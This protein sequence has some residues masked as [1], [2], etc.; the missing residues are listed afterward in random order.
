MPNSIG[1]LASGLN[2]ADIINAILTG[3]QATRT[4][5]VSRQSTYQTQLNA[6]QDLNNRLGSLRSAAEALSTPAKAAAATATSSDTDLVSVTAGTGAVESTFSFKV[7]Q[8]AASHQVMANGFTDT[9]DLVGAGKAQVSAGLAGIGMALDNYTGL[10]AGKYEVQIKS[11]SGGSATVVFNGKEQSVSSSG[12]VTL[13]DAAGNS[14]DFTIGTLATGTATIGV[15]DATA[16]TSL[17]GLAGAIN[18]LGVGV[19]AAAVNK[20]DGT[21]TP[22]SFVLSARDPGTEHAVTMDFSNLSGVSGKTFSTLRAA[23]DARIVL[24]DGTTTITRSSNRL[25]DVIPGV[26]ID[27]KAADPSKEVTVTVD[28]DDEKVVQQAKTLVESLNSVLSAVKRSTS[29]DSATK[30]A[31]TLTGDSRMRR[32]QDALLEAMRYSDSGQDKEVLAQI[33]I[34]L[35]SNGLFSLDETKFR[36]ALSNDHTG[37]IRLLAGDGDTRTGAFGGLTTTVKALTASG[38]TVHG[39]LDATRTNI[40]SLDDRIA[41]EDQRLAL[42]ENRVRRQYTNLE[43]TMAQLSSQAA[44]LSNALG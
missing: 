31:A 4:R 37:T 22:T 30:T 40:S 14:A 17:S 24:A 26:T 9:T 20:K 21:A 33:G 44:G 5:L 19:S 35:G 28:N 16:T 6:W 13:T 18:N 27:L 39:A 34:S 29:Y 23:A 15:V 1:G 10:S 32:V 11:I 41:A 7:Q 36:S 43:S 42:V 38:G 25:T 12:T 2:T 3:E 8:L